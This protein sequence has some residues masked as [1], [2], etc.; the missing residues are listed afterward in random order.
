MTRL[1]HAP[2]ARR[3]VHPLTCLACA[4]HVHVQEL[5]YMNLLEQKAAQ[6]QHLARADAAANKGKWTYARGG[7]KPDALAEGVVIEPRF[8]EQLR[9]A[10]DEYRRRFASF[11]VGITRHA[12]HDL[13]FLSFRLDFN[14]FHESLKEVREAREAAEGAPPPTPPAASA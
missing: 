3:H 12:S 8:A 10:A 6:R 5:L 13:A 9:Q 1:E 7:P 11:F 4:W 14:E 2:H